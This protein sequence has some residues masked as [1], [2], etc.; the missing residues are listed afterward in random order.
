MVGSLTDRPA[1]PRAT[2]PG[3]EAV[4]TR[5]LPGRLTI[6]EAAGLRDELAGWL[7]G[8]SRLVLETGEI[9]AMDLAGLQLLIAFRRGA[10]QAGGTVRLAGPPAG[11]LLEVLV[12]AG[13]RSA[14]D[15]PTPALGQDPFWWGG[16]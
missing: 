13:F 5:V 7:A 15:G 10:R 9:E 16:D 2:A 11:V 1:N 14:S 6:N 8:C 4:A 12:R 3:A